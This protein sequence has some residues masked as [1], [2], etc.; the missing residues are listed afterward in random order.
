M[1]NK[2]CDREK[3]E[4]EK[5]LE[6]FEAAPDGSLPISSQPPNSNKDIETT[7]ITPEAFAQM[8]QAK[9]RKS[10]L[11]RIYKEKEEAWH[12]CKKQQSKKSM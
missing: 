2:P 8:M 6:E 5:A 7:Y 3:K 11:W 1:N 4:M 12:N 9:E 10:N